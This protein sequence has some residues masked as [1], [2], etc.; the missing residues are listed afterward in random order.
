MSSIFILGPINAL[1]NAEAHAKKAEPVTGPM[2][3]AAQ[4]AGI[5]LSH[6]PKTLVRVNAV[7]QLVGAAGLLTGRFPRASAA[8]L[9]GTVIPTTLAGHRFW[10]EG[11]PTDKQMQR[12]HF[13][14]NL[15]ILGGLIVAAGDTDGKPG[16]AWRARRA[17]KDARH[18][19]RHLA[20]TARREA[21]LAKAKVA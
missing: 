15:S 16:I 13:A 2:V 17:A 20:A 12:V 19:A 1:K 7:L 11:D 10:D 9:A 14:K 4:R 8:L 6:D 5:P 3:K 18:E 21:K